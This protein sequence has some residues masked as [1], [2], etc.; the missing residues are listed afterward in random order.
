[1]DH[2]SYIKSVF[3]SL[4]KEQLSQINNADTEYILFDISTFNAGSVI[5][6]EPAND[7]DESKIEDGYSFYLELNDAQN[8][9]ST[10]K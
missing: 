7:F 3:N 10:L 1:M 4:T 6:V 2:S 5:T 8:W 9:A